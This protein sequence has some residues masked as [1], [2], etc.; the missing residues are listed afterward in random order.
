MNIILK[1]KRN[2]AHKAIKKIYI[3]FYMYFGSVFKNLNI[4]MALNVPIVNYRCTH[5]QLSMYSSSIIDV[6]I[7]NYLMLISS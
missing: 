4:I 2:M 7:V 6:L 3:T 5:R 1:K